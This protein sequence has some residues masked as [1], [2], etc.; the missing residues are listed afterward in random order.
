[1]K[2]ALHLFLVWAP[3]INAYDPGRLA[4]VVYRPDVFGAPRIDVYKTYIKK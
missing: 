4:N 3:T 2:N 1:V